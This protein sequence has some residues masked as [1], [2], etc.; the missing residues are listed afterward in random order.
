MDQLDSSYESSPITNSIISEYI[1]RFRYELPTSPADRAKNKKTAAEKEFW[2]LDQNHKKKTHHF[3]DDEELSIMNNL[4]SIVDIENDEESSIQS[5]DSLD[6]V[7]PPPP[8]LWEDNESEQNNDRLVPILS[9]TSWDKHEQSHSLDETQKDNHLPSDFTVLNSALSLQGNEYGNKIH[10]K[11]DFEEE[12]QKLFSV[13]DNLLHEYLMENLELNR[14]SHDYNLDEFSQIN[15]TPPLPLEPTVDQPVMAKFSEGNLSN[16]MISD[17]SEEKSP[18]NPI[19]QKEKVAEVAISSPLSDSK[20][21]DTRTSF[22]LSSDDEESIKKGTVII[23]EAHDEDSQVQLQTDFILSR[24]EN[25]NNFIIPATI[26]TQNLPSP[27]QP[28]IPTQFHPP[29]VKPRVIID[30]EFIGN[31]LDDDIISQL[32]NQLKL[33]RLEILNITKSMSKANSIHV[34]NRNMG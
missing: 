7:P 16:S 29:V 25:L 26:S 24:P 18:I 5:E 11:F 13:C 17:L 22:Y 20:V 21:A 12:T 33:K 3:I 2:W 8:M 14:S 27:V 31:Y 34:E 32:W 10:P 6:P 19:Q 9:S 28:D 23:A 30:D 4:T 15:I 1:R